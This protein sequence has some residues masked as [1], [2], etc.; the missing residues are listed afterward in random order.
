MDCINTELSGSLQ[1]G[2][3][4][5]TGFVDVFILETKNTWKERKKRKKYE[6][7]VVMPEKDTALRWSFWSISR[8]SVVYAMNDL[9]IVVSDR[10]I[11]VCVYHAAQYVRM[12]WVQYACEYF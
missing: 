5:K 6:N 2:Q 7:E 1:D 8:G 9:F 4:P 3:S 11:F 12:M 10:L